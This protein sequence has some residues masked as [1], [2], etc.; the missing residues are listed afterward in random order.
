M[1]VQE[2]KDMEVTQKCMRKL[3]MLIVLLSVAALVP[4]MD[5]GAVAQQAGG[6]PADLFVSAAPENSM[7]VGAARKASEQGKP[8][9]L[10]GKIG[11][12]PN[13][14]ADKFAIFVLSDMTL[15][16]CTDGCP[17]AWD[18]CCT[19]RETVLDNVATIQV[20]DG[21]GKPL[22]ASMLGAN[23]LKPLSEVTVSGTVIKKGDKLFIVNAR[24]IYVNKP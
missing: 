5:T 12:L 10:R 1:N 7:E 2:R 24:N 16:P 18:Y 20:V 3:G 14:F 17:T 22:K 21:A 4:G 23:G 9:V 8:V 19:P 13:P 11:G 15:P 6:L